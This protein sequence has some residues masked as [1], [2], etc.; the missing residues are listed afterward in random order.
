MAT[1]NDTHWQYS[2]DVNPQDYGGKW[3]RRTT[4]RQYQVIE[5]TNMDDACGRDNEG[6]PTYVVEL[7]LVDLDAIPAKE[8]ES[9]WRSSGFELDT[10]G[11]G[12][13]ISGDPRNT[14][15]NT[16][17]AI[18]CYEHGCKAPLESWEG[19]GSTRMLKQARAAAHTYKRDAAALAA[20]MERPVN[21][22][23]ST[24]AEYMA[25]D[26]RSGILRGVADGD[27]VAELMLRLGV[28]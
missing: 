19:N 6:R 2:G 28:K 10:E 1:K 26:M 5:L 13:E 15:R 24:A 4:G 9:A 27:P 22:V 23:G 16:M 18:A 8:Q 12:H 25:G 17:T 14:L 20:R 11:V 3:Y 7:A 21:K